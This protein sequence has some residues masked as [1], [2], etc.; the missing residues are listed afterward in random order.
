MSEWRTDVENAPVNTPVLVRNNAAFSD[1]VIYV[2]K[3]W[4]NPDFE[5]WDNG[6]HSVH[7]KVSLGGTPTHWMPLPAPPEVE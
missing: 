5:S 7:C 3:N 6:W 4:Q 1:H 2:A